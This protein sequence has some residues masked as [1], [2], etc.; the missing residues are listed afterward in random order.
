MHRYADVV[1]PSGPDRAFTYSVPEEMQSAIAP[2]CRVLV[3]FG[4]KL[5]TGLVVNLPESTQ[6]ASLRPIADVLDSIPAFSPLLLSLCRW[7]ADYYMAPLNEVVRTA[8]PHGFSATSKRRVTATVP[9]ADPRVLELKSRAPRRFAL[10]RHLCEQ[11]PT[12]ITDLV[13]LAGTKSIHSVVNA[14]ERDGM[15]VSEEILPRPK[16][17]ARRRDFIDLTQLDAQHLQ[18]TLDA[19]PQRRA[20][21]RLFLEAVSVLHAQAKTDVD[22]L[23]LVK[24][25]RVSTAMV[26]PF[27]RSGLLHV[28]KRSVVRTPDFGTEQKTLDISL[29]RAQEEVLNRVVGAMRT[30]RL[31]TFLL[32]GVTGSGKT[33]VYI[34]CI[35][36]CLAAGRTAIVL[37][38][39]IS[40]TPQI[41]RRFKSHFGEQAQVV[42]SRMSPGERGDVWRLARSG[43]CRI[44]IG[45]RSA[46]FA[47]LEDLGLIV[48]DEEHEATYKQFDATPR[49]HARDV[50]IIRGRQ[51]N[52]VV[53]LGSATPSV[54]SYSNALNGK[55]TLL[56]LPERADA[57][58]LPDV[59]LVDMTRERR[60]VF[61][62]LK[63]SLPY[64]ERGRLKHFQQSSLS[65]VLREHIAA[66]I[67]RKEGI[68]LLQNRRG[69]APFISCP[70]CGFVAMCENCQV[71]LTYH[72]TKRH[73]RCHYCGLVHAPY[74]TCPSCG[75]PEIAMHGVGTQ[76]V[77]EELLQVFP[78]VRI[79]RMDLDTTARKG[80]HDRI[81]RKFGDREAD[82]LLGT[83]MVA[84]G[85]DFPHVTLVG[86]ISADTQMLLPDFRASERTFQLLTQVAGR[87][88]RS[89]LRGEVIVQTAQPDHRTL[90]HILDHDY[91]SFYDEEVASRSE[92]HYP[93]F[94]RLTLLE[95]KGENEEQVRQAAERLAAALKRAQGPFEILG[96]A[97][98]VIGKIQRMFRWHVILR[99]LKTADPSGVVTRG[100][101]HAALATPTP[102]GHKVQVI[103]D[104]DPVGLM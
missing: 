39:E 19:L 74:T 18:E 31:E 77:E 28:V 72:L 33:Q 20:K 26:A 3:P 101:L 50:A 4:R 96:P 9:L 69:F 46:L 6:L 78:G 53:V 60:E 41:V 86:V 16:D 5:A 66:R 29:N 80:A 8:L 1:L 38:P 30:K 67:E 45:P 42:H 79:V 71:S 44:V 59:R 58:V 2:G 22:L 90:T 63:A 82:I 13:R 40:L 43:S 89:S 91:R 102:S 51:S 12:L 56:E 76:R 11:G 85:L 75:S 49:Y 36:H 48:V 10:I 21:A 62:E 55:Y 14:L 54:E 88:G 57:A 32:H 95:A 104:V 103:V 25:T 73:L 81:L 24:E 68:I 93:P 97:P 52:A 27:K 99:T 7:I 98:A 34:E 17:R 84:K 83:Q 70:D 64:E 35:R 92:L 65:R 37:V 61:A 100:H 87:A 94:S 23:D 47:P 15:L